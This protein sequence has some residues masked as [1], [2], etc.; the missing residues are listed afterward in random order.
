[1][2]F[3]KVSDNDFHILWLTRD[4]NYGDYPLHFALRL[5]YLEYYGDEIA[6]DVGQYSVSL[7]AV[8]PEAAKDKLAGSCGIYGLHVEHLNTMTSLS[9]TELLIETGIYARLFNKCGNN[10]NALL[11]EARQEF[12]KVQMLFGFYMDKPQNAVGATGWDFIK[13]ELYPSKQEK[14]A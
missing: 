5:E 9:K 8:S 4:I 12:K 14:T 1:M 10:K 2:K 11:Q 7:L 13:G 3:K 6:H